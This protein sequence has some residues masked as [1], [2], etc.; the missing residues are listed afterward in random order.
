[1]NCFDVDGLEDDSVKSSFMESDDVSLE[2][3]I[4]LANPYVEDEGWMIYLDPGLKIKAGFYGRILNNPNNMIIS[5]G[6]GQIIGL[7]LNKSK[8]KGFSESIRLDGSHWEK[9][10]PLLREQ[11]PLLEISIR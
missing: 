11:G 6:S 5:E 3:M 4:F 8:F 2:R 7:A 10:I 9:V 1:M